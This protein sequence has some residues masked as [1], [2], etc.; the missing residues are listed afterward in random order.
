MTSI[1]ASLNIGALQL[2]LQKAMKESEGELT[3][4]VGSLPHEPLHAFVTVRF[5]P[6]LP[7]DPSRYFLVPD[8]GLKK[9]KQNLHISL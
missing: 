3:I 4:K 8:G 7:R 9:W 6:L 5:E 2:P 1:F